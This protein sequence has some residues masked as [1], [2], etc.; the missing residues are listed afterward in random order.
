MVGAVGG[1][2]QHVPLPEPDVV[3]EPVG[4]VVPAPITYEV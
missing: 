2:A 3:M 4:V 1:P